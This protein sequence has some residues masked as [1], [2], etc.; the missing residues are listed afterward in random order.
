MARED[1]I[2]PAGAV[3]VLKGLAQALA[4]TVRRRAE[5]CIAKA[6]DAD[7]IDQAM[8][9]VTLI[10]RAATT[11]HALQAAEDKAAARALDAKVGRMAAAMRARTPT[12]DEGD[13][14]DMHERDA[15]LDTAEG[16]AEI[17][18]D[19]RRGVERVFRHLEQKRGHP[20]S[21]D[22]PGGVGGFEKLDHQGERPATPAH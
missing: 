14:T 13:E 6:A 4:Q 7:S 12:P 21:G 1:D 18:Q 16:V 2:D 20:H 8:R 19:A 10:A 11:I 9:T 3:P 17:Y 15:R 22:V 5:A